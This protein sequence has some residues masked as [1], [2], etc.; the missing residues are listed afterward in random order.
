MQ[1]WFAGA[2]VGLDEYTASGAVWDH[3]LETGLKTGATTEDDNG[4][5]R[6]RVGVAGVGGRIGCGHCEGFARESLQGSGGGSELPIN[7]A[8]VRLGEGSL[9]SR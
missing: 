2:V 8:I 1:F 7:E 6:K 9:T 3:A 4:G 5:E